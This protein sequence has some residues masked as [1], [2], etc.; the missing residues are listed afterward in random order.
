MEECTAKNVEWRGNMTEH[1][2]KRE[3]KKKCRQC[4]RDFIA[5][6]K[7]ICDRCKYKKEHFL[8]KEGKV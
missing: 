5:E 4:G 1:K 6:K 3:Y 2:L 7:E 8:V